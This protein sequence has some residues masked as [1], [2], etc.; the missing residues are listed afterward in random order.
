MHESIQISVRPYALSDFFRL[1]DARAFSMT[2]TPG[3]HS[4]SNAIPRLVL[5]QAEQHRRR[6]A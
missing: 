6:Y 4:V 2:N 5:A 3:F 1:A